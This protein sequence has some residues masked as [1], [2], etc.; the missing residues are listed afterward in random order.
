[1]KSSQTL[2][3]ADP[4]AFV[5]FVPLCYR[6]NHALLGSIDLP[7]TWSVTARPGEREQLIRRGVELCPSL[8][9]APV[10]RQFVGLRPLRAK[11]VRL[12]AEKASNGTIIIHNYGHGGSGITLSW[13]C[14]GEVAD[15]VV[16]SVAK[17]NKQRAK[18]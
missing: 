13:G 7:D 8:E 14:A 9:S 4:T 3:D 2:C 18:L 16:K 12:E 17:G 6:R 10:V 5:D 11:G 15:L 1:M